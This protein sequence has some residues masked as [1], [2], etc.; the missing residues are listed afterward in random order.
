M[1][2]LNLL[3]GAGGKDACAGP[4]RHVHLR[5][6]RHE[7]TSPKFDVEDEQGVQW[8]VKLGQEPQSETAAT[9]FLWAAGYFVDEDYYLAEIKVH[10]YAEVAPWRGICLGRRH[11]PPARLER[12]LKE[13]KKLGTGTGSTILSSARGN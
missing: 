4:E 1:A 6:G 10:G 11:G 8:K 7:G 9:R 13:V 2:S 3:Y 12:K 5:Q